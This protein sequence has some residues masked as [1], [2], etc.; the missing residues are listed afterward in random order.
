MDPDLR[1]AL[2]E[3]GEAYTRGLNQAMDR[4]DRFEVELNRP[5]APGDEPQH[6]R[7]F[8]TQAY[9][10]LLRYGQER[11]DA[12]ERQA[13]V[14]TGDDSKGGYLAPAEYTTEVIRN[15]VQFSPIRELSRGMTTTAGSVLIPKR[16]A[17]GTAFFVGET[18][19]RSDASP[20]YGMEN[21][22]V[23]EMACYIDV[24]TAMLEDSAINMAAEIAL[25]LG[26]EFGRL[27][28]YSA[29]YGNSVKTFEGV[30]TNAQI[31][32]VQSGAA[33]TVTADAVIAMFYSLP[34][35]YRNRAT[36]LTNGASGLKTLRT[37][38]D[39]TGQ[40][41]WAP[42]FGST[43]ETVLGRPIREAVD[44]VDFVAG[45]KSLILCDWQSGFR[46]VDKIDAGLS[47]LRDPFSLATTGKVRLH[48]R[49]RVGAGVVRPEAFRI[50]VTGT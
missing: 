24:S 6:Q 42:G 39:G 9:A 50:M 47:I 31:T 18:E 32:T 48:A 27:E 1:D 4:L 3:L 2:E 29:L 15:L 23:N 45:S 19:P 40:Y 17:T 30:L 8:I 44:V 26:E 21:I 34:A 7:S 12:D 10:K 13:A 37:L 36:W 43:P 35:F 25:G 11:L 5:R 41:L 16:T 28:G 22:P 33:T 20:A 46:F 49:R 14:I 38:K